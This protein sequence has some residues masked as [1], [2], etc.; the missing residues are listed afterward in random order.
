[1]VKVIFIGHFLLGGPALTISDK[2]YHN[3]H[4]V[5]SIQSPN[6]TANK[7]LV[8]IKNWIFKFHQYNVITSDK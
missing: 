5:D 1:M 6:P 8:Q 4:F 7:D 3:P 2:F